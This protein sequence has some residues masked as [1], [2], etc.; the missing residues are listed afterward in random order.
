MRDACGPRGGGALFDTHA[1]HRGSPRGGDRTTLIAEFHAAAKCAVLDVLGLGLPCPSGDQHLA[2]HWE[3]D[4]DL[5]GG[6]AEDWDWHA[7]LL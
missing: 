4:G 3:W 5:D 7:D 2:S 6:P 1:V